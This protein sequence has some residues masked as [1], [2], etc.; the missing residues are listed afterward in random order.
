MRIIHDRKSSNMH[1]SSGEGDTGAQEWENEWV[2]DRKKEGDRKRE[3][4]QDRAK[5]Q[6]QGDNKLK[7]T[8]Q[9][10]V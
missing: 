4:S 6:R 5:D 9:W 10:W 1:L 8:N 2:N 7:E 3:G